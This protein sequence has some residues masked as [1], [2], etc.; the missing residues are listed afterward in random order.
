MS[1]LRSRASIA[2]EYIGKA[3][4]FALRLPLFHH[5]LS[6]KASSHLLRSHRL[7]LSLSLED[8]YRTSRGVCGCG[9]VRHWRA[10][11]AG[12]ACRRAVLPPR[13]TAPPY[14]AVFSG[15]P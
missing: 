5:H 11:S 7:F 15:S 3:Y 6:S 2:E 10:R 13:T 9:A 8:A 1:Y 14:A 4:V 12:R